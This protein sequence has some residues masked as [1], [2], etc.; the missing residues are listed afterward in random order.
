M[1]KKTEDNSYSYSVDYLAKTIFEY[2]LN[3]ILLIKEIPE[4]ESTKKSI[5]QY[6]ERRLSEIKGHLN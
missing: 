1:E 4:G 3:N 5:I 6:F 2:E